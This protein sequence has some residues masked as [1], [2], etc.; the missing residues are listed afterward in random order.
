MQNLE[1]NKD[2][3]ETSERSGPSELSFSPAPRAVGARPEQAPPRRRRAAAVLVVVVPEPRGSAFGQK[4]RCVKPVARELGSLL[5]L[6]A[7]H[8]KVHL[9]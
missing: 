6:N 4:K 1:I 2:G 5:S 3:R 8:V 7:K 9:Q